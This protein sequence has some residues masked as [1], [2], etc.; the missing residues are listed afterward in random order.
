[1]GFPVS[2]I[3]S[4][5]Q[6][7][8]GLLHVFGGFGAVLKLQGLMVTRYPQHHPPAPRIGCLPRQLC[9]FHRPIGF[10]QVR[11]AIQGNL[12]GT[13]VAIRALEVTGIASISLPAGADRAA[14]DARLV[15][16]SNHGGESS[17]L[18]ISEECA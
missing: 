6:R 10:S 5:G 4:R 3:G 11:D 8:S 15:A 14:Q 17:T 7:R 12:P 2:W 9:P 1:M 13:A 16:F 18:E